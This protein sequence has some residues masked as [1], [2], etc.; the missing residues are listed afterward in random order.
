[1][2]FDG[3]SWARQDSGTVKTL[4]CVFG[5]TNPHVFVVGNY[6]TIQG[7]TTPQVD[8]MVYDACTKQPLYGVRVVFDNNEA[9]FRETKATGYHDA[10]P[11]LGGTHMINFMLSGYSSLTGDTIDL[12]SNNVLFGLR[13]YL[14]P[15]DPVKYQNL[16][17]GTVTQ[18][19]LLG[20]PPQQ[21]IYNQRAAGKTITLSWG[22]SNSKTTITDADGYYRFDSLE[23]GTYTVQ[24]PA[25]CT[26]IDPSGT[27]TNSYPVTIP[28]PQGQARLYE[29]KAL[30]CQ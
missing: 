27:G 20:L 2:Y 30:Q 23:A 13:T 7:A 19:V 17:V 6:G 16:I 9:L 14:M 4:N 15:T 26:A 22:C 12:P 1:M 11:T 10:F 24:L 18:D 25:G 29:F 21:K 8:G 3:S 5:E 28:V